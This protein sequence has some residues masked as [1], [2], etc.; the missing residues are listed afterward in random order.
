MITISCPIKQEFIIEL[1][2][3]V[4]IDEVTFKYEGKSG[5]KLTFST[6]TDDK[7]K[8]VRIAK[9]TIKATEIGSVLYFQI[10]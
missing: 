9:S 10:V 7:E 3:G 5:I 8:A 4:T 1:L 2:D 6:N